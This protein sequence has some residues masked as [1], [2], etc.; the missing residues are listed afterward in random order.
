MLVIVSWCPIATCFFVVLWT[1]LAIRGAIGLGNIFTTC[2]IVIL[3]YHSAAAFLRILS[4]VAALFVL[5]CLLDVAAVWDFI[6]TRFPLAAEAIAI[7]KLLGWAACIVGIVSRVILRLAVRSDEQSK[8]Q[9]QY[10]HAVLHCSPLV[11]IRQ[12]II[13]CEFLTK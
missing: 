12:T 1:V 9:C 8:K 4:D 13:I 6:I 5:T 2:H 10:K 11:S 7:A 3:W